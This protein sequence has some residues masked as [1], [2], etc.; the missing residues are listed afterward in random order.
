MP[1]HRIGREEWAAARAELLEGERSSPRWPAWCTANDK[2]ARHSDRSQD[3]TR[4]DW[5][6]ARKELLRL[7]KERSRQGDE[8]SA[9]A[10][11]AAVGSESIGV[12]ACE[13]DEGTR[14]SPS[15]STIAQSAAPRLPLHV[16]LRGRG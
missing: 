12:T 6:A 11:A 7:E 2:K 4:D 15:C 1:D 9:A 3:R 10:P 13:T 8:L 5:L 14:R 16:R